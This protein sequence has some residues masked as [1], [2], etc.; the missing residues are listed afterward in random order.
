MSATMTQPTSE[1]SAQ[2]TQLERAAAQLI[3]RLS[4]RAAYASAEEFKEIRS[5]IA[6]LRELGGKN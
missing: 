3:A 4:D 5:L 6:M 2:L 1:L